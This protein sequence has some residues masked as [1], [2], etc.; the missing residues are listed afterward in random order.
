MPAQKE[1]RK[2]IN[3]MVSKKLLE[4]LSAFVPQ[5]QRSDF[6]NEALKEALDLFRR[7]KSVE[8]MEKLRQEMKITISNDELIKLK[9]YGRE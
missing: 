3:F 7:R 9:N 1:E 6:V 4:E 8:N 2:K 5:G